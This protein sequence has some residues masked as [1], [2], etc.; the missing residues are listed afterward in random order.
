VFCPHDW[1]ETRVVLDA[2]WYAALRATQA[3]AEAEQERKVPERQ[4]HLVERLHTWLLSLVMRGALPPRER[5][6]AGL[7]L[8][9][10]LDGDPRVRNHQWV[11]VAHARPYRIGKYPVPN[12]QY[13]YFIEAG[14]Y[15]VAKAS[16]NAYW[17]REGWTWR[18][19]E[20]RGAPRFWDDTTLI[21]P[22]QPVVGVTWYEA[23]A[24]CRWL[25][26]KLRTTSEIPVNEEVRLPREVEWEFAARGSDNRTWPWGNDWDIDRANT[27]E[28]GL[29]TTTPVGIYPSGISPCGAFDMAGNVWEWCADWSLEGQS[30]RLRGGSWSDPASSAHSG[31]RDGG[32]PEYAY[33]HVGFRCVIARTASP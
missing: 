15:G 10:L 12:L 20:K 4:R 31:L 32:K 13:Q 6:Q 18:K 5:A 17:S 1:S 3:L 11:P 25:T 7:L 27:L 16:G 28:G 14:G 24:Y 23:E 29:Q 30:R 19:T 9:R 33:R 22:N 26:E 2:D 8:N 21:A